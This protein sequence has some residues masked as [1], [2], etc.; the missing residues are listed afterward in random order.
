MKYKVEVTRI[1]AV[2]KVYEVEAE[3][4]TEAKDMAEYNGC[5]DYFDHSE[6]HV[7]WESEIVD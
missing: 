3:T 2:T 6:G 4:E 1:S 5:K 7:S